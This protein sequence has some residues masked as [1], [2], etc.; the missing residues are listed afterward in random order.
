MAA[1]PG[2][3]VLSMQTRGDLLTGV[4]C[5]QRL[6]VV[7]E[8]LGFCVGIVA[9]VDLVEILGVGHANTVVCIAMR[10]PII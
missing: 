6:T 4:R 9:M 3:P 5:S 7:Y 10:G 2:R 1:A 8:E